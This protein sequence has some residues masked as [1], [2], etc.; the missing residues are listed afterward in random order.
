ASPARSSLRRTRRAR[1]IQASKSAMAIPGTEFARAQASSSERA[2]GFLEITRARV[3]PCE[4]CRRR[5]RSMPPNETGR[6]LRKT[7]GECIQEQTRE[8]RTHFSLRLFLPGREY[9]FRN[10]KSPRLFYA[11]Q[12][13][14]RH[15]QPW[16]ALRGRCIR[17]DFSYATPERLRTTCHSECNHSTRRVRWFDLSTRRGPLRV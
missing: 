6:V 16:I 1:R 8:C 9:Y 7:T 13:W 10:Q 11:G 14:H 4:Q 17:L 15:G 12:A 2:F 3:C 5:R